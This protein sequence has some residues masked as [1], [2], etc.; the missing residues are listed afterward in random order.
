MSTLMDDLCHGKKDNENSNVLLYMK[1]FLDFLFQGSMADA[2]RIKETNEPRITAVI[3]CTTNIPNYL[4]NG[5]I[6]YLQLNLTEETGIDDAMA[7][8]VVQFIDAH[9]CN[10]RNTLVHC[11]AGMQRSPAIILVYLLSR[12]FRFFDSLDTIK[13]RTG[14]P[15][16]ITEPMLRSISKLK[17]VREQVDQAAIIRYLA[18]E[19]KEA[20]LF[21]LKNLMEGGQPDLALEM[22]LEFREDFIA[23]H[24]PVDIDDIDRL[25]G[26]CLS[27]IALQQRNS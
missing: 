10:R 3:N 17:L 25:I 8:A 7:Q 11:N 21:N 4:E 18:R 26:E 6:D 15:I 20:M 23:R 14:F 2:R 1:K 12:G 5:G 24:G 22:L 27:R 13:Q 9:V 19:E 16:T